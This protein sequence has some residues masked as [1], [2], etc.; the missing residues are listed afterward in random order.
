M[1]KLLLTLVLSAVMSMPISL[2]GSP[3][4]PVECI[5]WNTDMVA[6]SEEEDSFTGAEMGWYGKG[7]YY[8][9]SLKEE[10]ALCDAEGNISV[11]S[12]NKYKLDVA[13]NNALILE[14]YEDFAPLTFVTPMFASEVH[15]LV[16]AT[17]DNYSSAKDLKFVGRLNYSDDT[18]S[19]E[20]E[21]TVGVWD[22]S[23]NNDYEALN[24]LGLYINEYG[25]LYYSDSMSYKVYEV[26][27][28]ADKNRS[29]AGASFHVEGG[30]WG[31]AGY[32]LGVSS[33]GVSAVKEKRLEAK[34]PVNEIKIYCG[35]IAEFNIEYTVK[36]DE[37][38][39][40][41][42]EYSAYCD[43]PNVNI[44][45]ITDNKEEGVITVAVTA[46]Q[47]GVATISVT[48][49]LGDEQ[50][51]LEGQLI[52][53]QKVEADTSDCVE[54]SNWGADVIA[55]RLPASNYTD[56]T[57]SGYNT[58]LYTDDVFAE[59]H[60]A[61]QERLIVAKSGRVYKLGAYDDN[62]ATITLGAGG[63]GIES[64]IDFRTPI[65]TENINLLVFS[66]EGATEAEITVVY[67][68]D[69]TGAVQTVHVDAWDEDTHQVPAHEVGYV[70]TYSDEITSDVAYRL[71]E[72]S[73]VAARNS[74]VKGVRIYNSGYGSKLV[75]LGVNAKDMLT[76]E[77]VKRLE[78]W[79]DRND[80]KTYQ[81]QPAE[82]KVYYSIKEKDGL[83]LEYSA[84]CSNRNV[85]IADIENNKADSMLTIPVSSDKTGL[86]NITVNL[87]YGAEH[88]TFPC[89][90]WVKSVVKADVSDCVEITNWT[91]DVIAES[92]PAGE[93]VS[94]TVNGKKAALY[95]DDVYP[96]G[97][98][99]GDDRI[100]T[101]ISGKVYLLGAYDT[102]NSAVLKSDNPVVTL[103]FKTPI[104][105]EQLNILMMS[106]NSASDVEVAA[107]YADDSMEE[108]QLIQAHAWNDD[109]HYEDAI[110]A[111][112]V[113]VSTDEVSEYAGRQMFEA[114]VNVLREHKVKGVRIENKSD[115]AT[116][117]ILGAN[118][119]DMG[120]S[121]SYMVR[122]ESKPA[123]YYN[124]Q[125]IRVDKLSKGIYIVKYE[126]GTSRK[127]II[128]NL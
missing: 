86:A 63:Y 1:R 37:T 27:L 121:G 19:D 59:G 7:T 83:K 54:V 117:T 39:S 91:D 112:Y 123:A 38:S 10:G 124:L 69:T 76:P 114:S 16:F 4:T 13:G 110:T 77:E 61:G 46:A 125:G 3:A 92:L 34:M 105:T 5:G 84:D 6:E 113:N 103:Y 93:H 40:D 127:I 104:Y 23:E 107:L 12:G 48:L 24:N 67:D 71:Y 2:S 56:D 72:I 119:I 99:A 70:N 120:T 17:N 51:I 11:K 122:N 21:F 100:I 80:V 20:Y 74:K 109:E 64:A 73:A 90:L 97:F 68:D 101:G 52:V 66:T 33:D 81:G 49:T 36:E 29:L 8:S 87:T 79:V 88:L 102:N 94:G 28:P 32:V 30:N 65:Y 111:G 43:N 89:T 96:V 108:A 75:V 128:N 41:I 45:N 42:L 35:E 18:V 25:D 126:D 55:E 118:A 82:F 26:S 57:V 53:K 44:A 95:T 15:F 58:V 106:A 47:A 31:Q 22:V 78:A 60:I 62:N 14:R 116:L 98:L 115:D 9:T 85:E 50:C